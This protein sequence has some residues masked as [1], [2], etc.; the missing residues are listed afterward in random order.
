[1]RCIL[2]YLLE[3]NQFWNLVTPEWSSK[4]VKSEL[5]MFDAYGWLAKGPAGMNYIPV[6]VAEHEIPMMVS[7]YQMGIKD[8]DAKKVLNAAV[9]MQTTPAQ[10][11]F[12]GFA[13][14]RD[15][16][17]Y[18]QYHYVPSD[19]VVSPIQWNIP[20]TTGVWGNW[21]NHWA[22]HLFI[23]P[24]TTEVTGGRMRLIKT[25]IVT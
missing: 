7:A 20:M 11:I 6:M 13:G 2:E 14:N 25:G 15:L 17:D 24:I 12:T 8:F 16:K 22:I 23:K 3:F 21:Q 9:K 18:L 1:M 19:K 4:W 10:K 5:A